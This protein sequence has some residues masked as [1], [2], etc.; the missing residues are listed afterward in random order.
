M[1]MLYKN[2]LLWLLLLRLLFLVWFILFWSGLFVELNKFVIK[3]DACNVRMPLC[4]FSVLFLFLIYNF[5]CFFV[6][7]WTWEFTYILYCSCLFF[8]TAG[9]AIDYQPLQSRTQ[10]AYLFV[11]KHIKVNLACRYFMPIHY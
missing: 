6:F 4:L 2:N 1:G 11:F 5:F 10:I 8:H 3:L 7:L 9:K